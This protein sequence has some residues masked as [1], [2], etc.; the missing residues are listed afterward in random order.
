MMKMEDIPDSLNFK[1]LDVLVT[2]GAGDIDKLAEP[3]EEKIK[4]SYGI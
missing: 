1:E 4:K 2:I 3:I